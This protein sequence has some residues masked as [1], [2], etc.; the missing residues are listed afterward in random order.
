MFV[1]SLSESTQS[2]TGQ[3]RSLRLHPAQ[4]ASKLTKPMTRNIQTVG[5]SFH[6]KDE[7]SLSIAEKNI[8]IT[9]DGLS[10][11][12]IKEIISCCECMLMTEEDLD[13]GLT[14]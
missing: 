6:D 7:Y 9:F 1:I 5:S 10:R 11:E 4:I 3:K 14:D 2:L 13:S 8:S 12:D